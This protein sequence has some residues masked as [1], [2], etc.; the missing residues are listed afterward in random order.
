MIGK[1][2]LAF[3][4]LPLLDLYLLVKVAGRLGLLETVAL[5]V[6]TGV[7]GGFVA[8]LQG[9]NTLRKAQM[10]LAR[11]QSP[12]DEVADGALILV[13]GALLVT[14]GLLTDG[15]GFLLLLPFTRP[16]VRRWLQRYLR[17][18]VEVVRRDVGWGGGY[19]GDDGGDPDVGSGPEFDDG[20]AVDVEWEDR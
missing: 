1:L 18:R 4:A 5:V 16:F 3:V 9:L 19:A 14:P 15:L 6:V 10:R 11:R 8:R 20:D 7:V 17:G 2:F 13:G 12:S